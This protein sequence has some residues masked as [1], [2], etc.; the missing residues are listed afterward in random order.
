MNSKYVV[1]HAGRQTDY[2]VFWQYFDNYILTA[3]HYEQLDER[4]LSWY[5]TDDHHEGFYE[6]IMNSAG[7]I[8]LALLYRQDQMTKKGEKR[9]E[10]RGALGHLYQRRERSVSE[11]L[12]DFSVRRET[13]EGRCI[14]FC[15]YD[16]SS[17]SRSVCQ[18]LALSIDPKSEDYSMKSEVWKVLEGYLR[19]LGVRQLSTYSYQDV[20]FWERNGF[21]Q[22]G[23]HSLSKNL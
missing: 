16:W 5:L 8:S 23:A 13:A 18:I 11:L 9:R 14:G 22:S 6:Q 3:S 7:N 21:R 1:V 20:G 17:D 15:V 2:S 19:G 4:V 10:N 12:K